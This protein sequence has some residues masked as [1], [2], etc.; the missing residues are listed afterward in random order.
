MDKSYLLHHF[1]ICSI[2]SS[3]GQRC[4][5]LSQN[6]AIFFSIKDLVENNEP[7]FEND[8]IIIDTEDWYYEFSLDNQ[9]T[10][11]VTVTFID[12]AKIGT[13][14]TSSTYA[15]TYSN[16]SKNW[17]LISKTLNFIAGS[18][19]DKKMEGKVEKFEPQISFI[20]R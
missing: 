3:L 4:K 7:L 16:K 8:K 9:K 10:N 6:E 17:F 18:R 5:S 19:E 2:S 12:D 1:P 20:A 11:R 14:F 13:Y 15:L